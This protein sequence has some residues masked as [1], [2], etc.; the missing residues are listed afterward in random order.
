MAQPQPQQAGGGGIAAEGDAAAAAGAAK[1]ARK[2]AYLKHLTALHKDQHSKLQAKNQQEVELLEDIRTFMKAR[3]VAEKQYGDAL[4]K[5]STS[6]M[7]RK[8]AALPDVQTAEGEQVGVL[9]LTNYGGIQLYANAIMRAI[10]L[11]R[12]RNVN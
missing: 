10:I 8:I 2:V 1:P 12:K 6:H 9:G 3:A 4:L 5:L 11:L 7:N